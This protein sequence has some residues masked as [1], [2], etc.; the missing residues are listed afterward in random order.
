MYFDLSNGQLDYFEACL[1]TI[2]SF[3]LSVLNILFVA[4]THIT[5][6]TASW[7]HVRF[8]N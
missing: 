2:W 7:K 4:K 5:I 8:Q 6:T 1:H 3:F